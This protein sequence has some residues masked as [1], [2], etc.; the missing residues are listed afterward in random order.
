MVRVSDSQNKQ[1]F[2]NSPCQFLHST[3]QREGI[4]TSMKRHTGV[5]YD[6]NLYNHVHY[7]ANSATFKMPDK[8]PFFFVKYGISITL[9][10][11]H[12]Y[13]ISNNRKV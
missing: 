2:M 6:L 7:F 9:K 13:R 11:S 4:I 5:R 10:T 3:E 12:Y 8:S 1:V